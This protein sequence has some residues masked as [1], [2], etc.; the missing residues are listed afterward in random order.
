MRKIRPKMPPT[1]PPIIGVFEGLCDFAMVSPT[2]IAVS[3]AE[4]WDV[5]EV[6]D[7]SVETVVE[8]RGAAV[9]TTALTAEEI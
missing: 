6:L 9:E 1:V 8:G 7:T 2:M 5:T 4:L 3:E